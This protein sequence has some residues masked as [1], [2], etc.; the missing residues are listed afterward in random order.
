MRPTTMAAGMTSVL[1][2]EQAFYLVEAVQELVGEEKEIA[3]I[4]LTGNVYLGVNT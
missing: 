3:N 2:W 1:Y 4:E